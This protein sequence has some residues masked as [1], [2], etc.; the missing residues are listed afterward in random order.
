MTRKVDAW[1]KVNLSLRVT[2]KRED[3]Y[4][5]ISSIFSKVGLGDTLAITATQDGAVSV[6]CSEPGVPCDRTNLA[7]RAAMAL[8]P[9]ARPGLGARIEI[10][11]RIPVAAGLGGGSS[12]AA[13]ALQAL[14]EMWEVGLEPDKLAELAL[15]LGAD[16]P[17]FLGGPMAHVQGIGEKIT[18]LSPRRPIPMILANPGF[19]I[20]AAE[21]YRGGRFD[22]RPDPDMGQVIED[23]ER[24][25]PA[26][27]ARHMENDLAPWAMEEY[28]S[29]G[30][31]KAALERLDPA[32]L[33]VAMSGSGPTLMAIYPT[34]EAMAAATERAKEVAPWVFGV[35]TL[36]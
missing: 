4:H 5:L 31:L 8:Q 12:D 11:K 36:V 35:M 10:T 23:M 27:V 24:G 7:V 26:R 25:D 19:G 16:V 15:G 22:F 33:T 28:G 21:A 29:L 14:N 32:P 9:M 2:G 6:T 20:S 1:A 18:P 30:R 13:A 3:G 34:P 17:F